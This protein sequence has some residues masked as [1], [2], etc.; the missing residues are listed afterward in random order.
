MPAKK[1]PSR[2]KLSTF[3][4]VPIKVVSEYGICEVACTPAK[5]CKCGYH[6]SKK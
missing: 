4:G 1:K 6:K 3:C 2:A 5:K